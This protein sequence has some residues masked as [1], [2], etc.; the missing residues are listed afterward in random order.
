MTGSGKDEEIIDGLKPI[1]V[2]KGIRK[3]VFL[4]KIAAGCTSI[5]AL[6][7]A[8]GAGRGS[9]GGERCTPRIA[10]LLRNRPRA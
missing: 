7:T 5:E 1:C 3:R 8:T 6:R 2:C 4:E 10:E 9:C